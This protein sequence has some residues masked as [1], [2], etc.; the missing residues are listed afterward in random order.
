[1]QGVRLF[2]LFNT[3]YN[4]QASALLLKMGRGVIQQI[5]VDYCIFL[6]LFFFFL[7]HQL[8]YVLTQYFKKKF[9]NGHRQCCCFCEVVLH[10]N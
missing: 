2:L 6:V 9:L 7:N 8:N 3:Y 1:M 4:K 10:C 5:S